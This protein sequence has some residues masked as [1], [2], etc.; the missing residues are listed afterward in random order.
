MLGQMGKSVEGKARAMLSLQ[1]ML[2]CVGF[3]ESVTEL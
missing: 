1:L 2:L 3:F